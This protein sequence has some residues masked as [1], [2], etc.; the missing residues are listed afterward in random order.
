[1]KLELKLY[2]S[3]FE[4]RTIFHTSLLR[5]SFETV[6]EAANFAAISPGKLRECSARFK[7]SIIIKLSLETRKIFNNNY[8]LITLL[9]EI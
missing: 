5:A 4:V 7:L 1:M 8:A 6:L 2:L 9:N 3:L